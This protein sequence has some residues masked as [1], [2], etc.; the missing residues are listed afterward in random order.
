MHNLNEEFK[1]LRNKYLTEG[2]QEF[3]SDEYIIYEDDNI[4]VK[5]LDPDNPQENKLAREILVYPI[6]KVIGWVFMIGPIGII[7][8]KKTDEHLI[9]AIDLRNGQKERVW[10]KN[11]GHSKD[12]TQ[13]K[14][15]EFFNA[16]TDV[17]KQIIKDIKN[18][19]IHEYLENAFDGEEYMTLR[20]EAEEQAIQD[21]DRELINLISE[22]S[23]I[24]VD[25]KDFHHMYNYVIK[26]CRTHKNN[27]FLENDDFETNYDGELFCLYKDYSERPDVTAEIKKCVEHGLRS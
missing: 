3:L 4:L 23:N 17:A 1:I 2:M 5:A 10:F 14:I 7:L 9:F 8:N 6:A 20:S 13:D 11:D 21:L 25:D 26:H 12:L 22:Y 24:S 19:N 16:E 18:F 27:D 15:V